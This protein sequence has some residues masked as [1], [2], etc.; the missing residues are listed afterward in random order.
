MRVGRP[1]TLA[2]LLCA[3]PASA[4]SPRWFAPEAA[5]PNVR[6]HSPYV[7][8][9]LDGDGLHDLTRFGRDDPADLLI[10]RGLGDSTFAPATTMP[11]TKPAT[12]MA[13]KAS[14]NSMTPIVHQLGQ[15]C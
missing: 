2:L 4:Q 14:D 3:L 7:L 15:V 11:T 1:T 6:V 10:E 9:D 5:T 8:A 13:K 12:R